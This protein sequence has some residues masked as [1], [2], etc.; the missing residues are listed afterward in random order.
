VKNV[1]ACVLV[2]FALSCAS[3]HRAVRVPP[4]GFVTVEPGVR[5]AYR[6][7]GSGPETLVVPWPDATHDIDR[8]AHG[9]R[10]ILYNPRGRVASDLVDPSRVSFE[11]ELA[12]LEAVRRLFGLERMMLLGW[13]HYGMMTAVYTIRH[14]E[15]VARL[16]QMTP[17]GPRRTPYLDQGMKTI[18]E[19]VNGDD[20]TRLEER[21]KAGEFAGKPDALC[22]ENRRVT[23]AAFLAD[24]RDVSKISD[25]VCRFATEQAENQDKWWAALF[26]SIGDWDYRGDARALTMPRLVIQGE[27]D[28]IP[29]DGS[30][31][32]VQGNPN[33]RLLVIPGAGHF[34]H[35]ERPDLYFPA[36]EKFLSG[37]WPDGAVTVPLAGVI[38]SAARDLSE[39]GRDERVSTT[40][41]VALC[42]HSPAHVRRRRSVPSTLRVSE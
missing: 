30:R 9:R 4:E 36:V 16:V 34:P 42:G 3:A 8:L 24:P 26:G 29:M 5:V 15:R 38:P 35:L 23:L 37:G 14:P 19:R 31:E 27:K 25:E 28:F 22:R 20:W 13:S 6:I 32:W 10:L 33:A 39:N 11:N 17:G 21:K 12:D 40:A 2:P 7:V 18:R 1:L 41:L